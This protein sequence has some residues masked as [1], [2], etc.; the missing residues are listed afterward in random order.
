MKIVKAE[1]SL[2]AVPSELFSLTEP[3]WQLRYKNMFQPGSNT[4]TPL[5]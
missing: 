1:A 3:F 4:A 2:S 5:K